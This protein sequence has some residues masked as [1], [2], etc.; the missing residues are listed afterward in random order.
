PQRIVIVDDL[1]KGPTGK[2]QRR[3]LAESLGLTTPTRV[4]PAGTA[5]GPPLEEV[6]AGLWAQVLEVER[7]GPHDNFYYL[8]GDSILATQLLSRIRE[9]IHV[10]VSF[11]SFFAMP[12][13]A[14]VARSIET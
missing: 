5:P 2:L 4:P 11:R 3:G 13:V 6:L 10:E 1:P 7:V 9:A 14:G 12:T 8:G